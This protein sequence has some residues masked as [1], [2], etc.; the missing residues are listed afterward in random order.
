MLFPFRDQKLKL[1][2]QHLQVEKQFS[3]H[4]QKAYSL[5]LIEFI[6]KHWNED[7]L[8]S[9]LIPWQQVSK[10]DAKDF[11]FSLQEQKI[12]KMRNIIRIIKR[13]KSLLLLR[14]LKEP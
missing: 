3:L 1:F 2:F 6:K 10:E 14:V 7:T 5:D 11:V 12:S 9:S 8:E 13:E 4:T